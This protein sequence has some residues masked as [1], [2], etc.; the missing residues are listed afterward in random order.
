MRPTKVF[1]ILI[2]GLTGLSSC[3]EQYFPD[4]TKEEVNTLVITGGISDKEGYNNFEVSLATNLGQPS[5]FPV[6]GCTGYVSDDLGNHFPLENLGEGE[7][8]VWIDQQYLQAGKKYRLYVTSPAGLEYESEEEEMPTTASIDSL[9]C[10]FEVHQTSDPSLP[11]EGYQFYADVSGLSSNSRYY[12]LVVEETWEYHSPYIIE[13]YW[14]GS[15]KSIRRFEYPDISK[16]VCYST[17][18][19]KKIFSMSTSNLAEN[20]YQR[21]PLHFIENTE[22]KLLYNYSVLVKQYALSERAYRYWDYLRQNIE[23]QEG[24][25][26]K[27]PLQ[28]VGNIHCKTEPGKKV[29]GFFSVSAMKT[30]RITLTNLE[31]LHVDLSDYCRPW[32]PRSGSIMDYLKTVAWGKIVYLVV[33]DNGNFLA[34]E[35]CFDCRLRGGTTVKPVFLP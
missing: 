26:Q 16:Q 6:V 28:I 1:A 15:T 30:K 20:K 12:R 32:L 14:D 35:S 25:Y 33:N 2:A 9:Y 10:Q 7:Y 29:L 31:D 4:F 13:W 5:Y 24:L 22:E 27:Q 8:R 17:K 3:L 23:D 18:D 19:V 11:A 21:F 34:D